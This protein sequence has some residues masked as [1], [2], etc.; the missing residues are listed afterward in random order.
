VWVPRC[1]QNGG[2]ESRCSFLR[3]A[4]KTQRV[5]KKNFFWFIVC[6][7]RVSLPCISLMVGSKARK[8]YHPLLVFIYSFHPI[9]ARRFSSQAG[10]RHQ[11][12][13]SSDIVPVGSPMDAAKFEI[14]LKQF[15]KKERIVVI[16][17]AGMIW[18]SPL[19]APPLLKQ[20]HYYISKNISKHVFL[21]C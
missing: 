13:A 1:V 11:T 12:H 19:F 16:T 10:H 15:E 2:N 14:L 6:S 20:Y 17:G 8:K 7:F 21:I 9:V 5:I 4:T 3:V 18:P